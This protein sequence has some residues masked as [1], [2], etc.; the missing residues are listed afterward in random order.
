MDTPR[1]LIKIPWGEWWETISLMQI[2]NYKKKIKS[3]ARELNT[4]LGLP[5]TPKNLKVPIAMFIN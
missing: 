2:I 4:N 5:P 3:M 1:P